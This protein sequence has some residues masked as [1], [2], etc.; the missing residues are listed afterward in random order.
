MNGYNF[1]ERV[2]RSLAEAREE[3]VRLRHEDVQTQ[4]VLFALLR[5][6]SSI[7]ADVIAAFGVKR[8]EVAR[9]L[10]ETVKLGPEPYEPR[11]DVP[12]SARAKKVLELTMDEARL[13]NHSY[14]GTQ[15]L[16]LGLIREEQ[17]VAA[18][19]LAAFGITLDAARERV[20]QILAAGKQDDAGF[21]RR[22]AR[23]VEIPKASSPAWMV[24]RL[25]FP[26]TDSTSMA[27][28]LIEVLL[29]DAAIAGVFAAQRIDA[30]MLLAALRS[31]PA[32]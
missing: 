9:S 32:A 8:A 30:G 25:N 1:T 15:H 5:D 11:S 16:L 28:S 29:R 6:D 19:V 3:A 7:A 21:Q 20:V 14:V 13:L 2:R 24:G 18:Q 4:H 23:G 26:V 27:A 12:Y 10:E 22:A 31:A 17:G